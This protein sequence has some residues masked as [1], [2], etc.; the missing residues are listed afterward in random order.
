MLSPN[1]GKVQVLKELSVWVALMQMGIEM[2]IDV[3]SAFVL[4]GFYI[5][6]DIAVFDWSA[7]S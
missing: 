6:K 5:Y 1:P 7:C 2:M 4:F 3:L